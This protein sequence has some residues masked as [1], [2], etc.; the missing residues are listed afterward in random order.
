MASSVTATQR[1]L[2][3]GIARPVAQF[4]MKKPKCGAVWQTKA[5]LTSLPGGSSGAERS[6]SP[7][8]DAAS[9]RLPVPVAS[10]EEVEDRVAQHQYR[11]FMQRPTPAQRP[12]ALF[13]DRAER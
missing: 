3:Q 4:T 1:Y 9:V 10:C 8:G 12:G 6:A 13:G 2:T 11:L 7:S 5:C